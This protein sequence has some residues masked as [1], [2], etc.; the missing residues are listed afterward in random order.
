M[1]NLTDSPFAMGLR[2]IIYP[3]TMAL[4][5]IKV[6]YKLIIEQNYTP[7]E[8]KPI[9][10]ACNHSAFPDTPLALRS[11]GRHA[12]ALMG[13]Q[14]L[15]PADRLFFFLTGSIWVDRR[16]KEDTALTKK[17]LIAFLQKE[18]S[19]LWCPEATWNL[20]ENLLMLPMK[21]GV[22]DIAKETGAQ[23]IPLVLE[24]DMENKKCF[25]RFGK[26]MLFSGE[27]T[28]AEAIGTLRDTMAAM[29]WEFWERKGVFS[30]AELDI[31]AE[32]QK[33]LL[34]LEEYPPLNWDYE[35]SCIFWPYT[36]P[37]DAFAHLDGLIPRREN[38]FL[39][40]G[41]NL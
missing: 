1:K 15:S 39:F 18:R 2:A 13:K 22:I 27:E 21:W 23:V 35:S 25:A 37:Q 32:R 38:A 7:L 3:L 28:K 10:F 30:R 17:R 26:P 4:S 16:N 11:F 34:P 24:Y 9:I 33:L 6:K 8:H 12:Y 31:E 40:R 20:T 36:K 29:R 14:N 5:G 41:R 19:L